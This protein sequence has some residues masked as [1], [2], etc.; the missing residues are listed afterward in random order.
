[1]YSA[2]QRNF[3]GF[4]S[5]WRALSGPFQP[6]FYVYKLHYKQACENFFWPHLLGHKKRSSG[7]QLHLTLPS[8]SSCMFFVC[9][10]FEGVT[11][12]YR[13]AG[14][15]GAVPPFKG[16]KKKVQKHL[17]WEKRAPRKVEY[18]NPERKNNYNV[19]TML[20]SQGKC[21]KTAV[22]MSVQKNIAQ[23]NL[24][25][26]NAKENMYTFF[27]RKKNPFE[28]VH[29]MSQGMRVHFSLK[30]R[31]GGRKNAVINLLQSK[32]GELKT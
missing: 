15:C 5:K 30:T 4:I 29:K 13:N 17:G 2:C 16:D 19:Y 1:M 27:S 18:T 26:I 20:Y 32:K 10:F 9:F 31:E 23:E 3:R 6:P 14:K 28:K 22:A 24:A 21:K 12:N 8:L 7:T 11:S 25:L